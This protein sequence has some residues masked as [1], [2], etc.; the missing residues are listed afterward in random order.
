[1]SSRYSK[2][3]HITLKLLTWRVISLT[4]FRPTSLYPIA[5]MDIL[6]RRQLGAHVVE[7]LVTG[8]FARTN[9]RQIHFTAFPPRRLLDRH[10][11]NALP[12]QSCKVSLK[13]QR[14]QQAPVSLL[15]GGLM[16]ALKPQ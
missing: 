3:L 4:A 7:V 14:T 1:M 12:V 9:T 15:C 5:M 10:Q 8:W 2:L 16:K 13:L 6:Q 11:F